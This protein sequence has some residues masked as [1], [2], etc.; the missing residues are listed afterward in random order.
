MTLVPGRHRKL[1]GRS[2]GT[3]VSSLHSHEMA[4]PTIRLYPASVVCSTTDTN[5]SQSVVTSKLEGSIK[6]KLATAAGPSLDNT[7]SSPDDRPDTPVY[8]ATPSSPNIAEY[9][10]NTSTTT[11]MAAAVTT[12]P[13]TAISGFDS[14]P[15]VNSAVSDVSS[16]AG[17]NSM[18]S[19]LYSCDQLTTDL[20]SLEDAMRAPATYLARHWPE[21]ARHFGLL[22]TQ[23]ARG[24]TLVGYSS[25]ENNVAI[26]PEQ[27]SAG[28]D[29]A[30]LGGP[31]TILCVLTTTAC[32]A[33]RVPDRRVFYFI[34]LHRINS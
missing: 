24:E 32:F 25:C 17:V 22:P 20:A 16:D 5:N 19:D 21:A 15:I 7:L 13:S 11:P 6:A 30:L 9:L 10:A 8:T 14:S 12:S 3:K 34:P 29:G 2:A 26:T 1:V 4:S 33:P 31:E 27:L 28:H 23:S 18:D